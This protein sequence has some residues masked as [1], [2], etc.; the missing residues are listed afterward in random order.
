MSYTAGFVAVE[1][2]EGMNEQPYK[3]MLIEWL[4]ANHVIPDCRSEYWIESEIIESEFEDLFIGFDSENFE[5]IIY[6]GSLFDLKETIGERI[7]NNATITPDSDSIGAALHLNSEDFSG[8]PYFAS[9]RKPIKTQDH[10]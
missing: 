10:E 8:T 7:V 6:D 3:D 4:E 5:S 2:T 9:F 1:Y